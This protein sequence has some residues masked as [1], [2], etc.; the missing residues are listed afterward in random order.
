MILDYMSSKKSPMR[1]LVKAKERLIKSK[2]EREKFCGTVLEVALNST[3]EGEIRSDDLLEIV[4]SL[5]K[6]IPLKSYLE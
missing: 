2:E 1:L 6:I 5:N 4:D 3:I